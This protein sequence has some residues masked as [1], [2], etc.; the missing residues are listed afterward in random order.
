MKTKEEIPVFFSIDDR[1]APYLSVAINSII[2]N[3]STD[4]QYKIIILYQ[5][6]SADNQNKLGQLE[7]KN[8]SIRFVAIT[9]DLANKMSHEQ[10]KLRGDYFTLTIYF[11]LFIAELFP[12]YDKAIYLDADIVVPSDLSN[13]FNIDLGDKLI[14]ASLDTFAADNRETV[15][16]VENVIGVPINKYFNSGVLLLNLKTLRE[17]QLSVKFL[18]LLNKYHFEILAPD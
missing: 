13:L 18:N 14:G 9:D 10:T 4:Y 16:Y 7:N 17:K 12:E 15:Q 2:A 6:L 5:S 11:R 8:F 3:S 1:Y